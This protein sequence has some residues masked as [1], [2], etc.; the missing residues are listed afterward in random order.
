MKSRALY[1][2][3]NCMAYMIVCV[4]A[5]GI[6]S[7]IL[8]FRC[9]RIPPVETCAFLRTFAAKTNWLELKNILN[10]SC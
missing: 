1:S 9:V 10:G 7:H 3:I 6:L 4:D 2:R 8:R 5:F